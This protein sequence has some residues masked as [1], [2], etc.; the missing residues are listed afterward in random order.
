M[1]GCVDSQPSPRRFLL[2]A[3][4]AEIVFHAFDSLRCLWAVIKFIFCTVNLFSLSME[5]VTN[6]HKIEA[7][8]IKSHSEQVLTDPPC[9][10]C[11]GSCFL[12]GPCSR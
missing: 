4:N 5:E 3:G 6:V 8:V 9:F 7:K 1:C 11:R 2:S 12:C 10:G